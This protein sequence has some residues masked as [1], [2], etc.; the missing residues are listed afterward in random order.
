[1]HVAL[2]EKSGNETLAMIVDLFV[3]AAIADCVLSVRMG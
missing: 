2:N 1:M 3:I